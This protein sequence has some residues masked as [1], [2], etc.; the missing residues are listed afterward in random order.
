MVGEPEPFAKIKDT[1]GYPDGLTVDEE[2][3]VWCAH[4]DGGRVTR[5]SPQGDIVQTFVLPVP[6]VTCCTFG[7]SEYAELY[8]TSASWGLSE[9]QLIKHPLSGALFVAKVGVRGLPS[10]LFLG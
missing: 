8:I 7:G 10:R 5:Y 9:A 3:C 6:R 1:D 2:G 4:W